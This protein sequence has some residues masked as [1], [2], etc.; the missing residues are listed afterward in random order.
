VASKRVK[1]EELGRTIK[2]EEER[3]NDAKKDGGINP[4]QD[5]ARLGRRPLQKQIPIEKDY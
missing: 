3:I 5:S 4:P 1:K 2:N